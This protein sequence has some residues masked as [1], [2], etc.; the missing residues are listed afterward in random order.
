MPSRII[1]RSRVRNKRVREGD[2]FSYVFERV[3]EAMHCGGLVS[4]EGFAVVLRRGRCVDDFVTFHRRRSE[5]LITTIDRKSAAT[6]QSGELLRSA[7]FWCRRKA[8]KINDA[9]RSLHAPL[10]RS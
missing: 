10:Q 8:S 5:R 1:R 4:G 2:P 9:V 3:V 6:G 7:S